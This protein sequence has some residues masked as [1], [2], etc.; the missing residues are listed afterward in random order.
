MSS[1]SHILRTKESPSPLTSLSSDSEAKDV[2]DPKSDMDVD[3]G[4]E[5]LGISPF[6]VGTGAVFYDALDKRR[7]ICHSLSRSEY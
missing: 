4:D 5:W 7:H 6:E 2:E 1:F 3:D